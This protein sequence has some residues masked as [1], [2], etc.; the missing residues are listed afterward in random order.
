MKATAHSCSIKRSFSEN[1]PSAEASFYKNCTP[2][3]PQLPESAS[4]MI[5]NSS[6]LPEQKREMV[7]SNM[8]NSS[9]KH[10]FTF[11]IPKNP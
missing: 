9:P 5:E 11:L 7:G 8:V 2:G 1:L 10:G 4:W 3:C 6:S